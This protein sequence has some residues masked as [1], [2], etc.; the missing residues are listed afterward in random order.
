MGRTLAYKRRGNSAA[1]SVHELGPIED[2]IMFKD[3]AYL[4]RGL[5][6]FE[7]WMVYALALVVLALLPVK[8]RTADRGVSLA[9]ALLWASTALDAYRSNPGWAVLAGTEAALL[10][11]IGSAWGRLRFEAR[12][13]F[14]AAAGTILTFYSLLLFP[15]LA[16]F[17][18]PL[19][20]RSAFGAPLP[21]VLFTCGILFLTVEP[22]ANLLLVLPLTWAFLGGPDGYRGPVELDGLEI[23]LLAGA[24]FLTLPPELRA[25]SDSRPSPGTAYKLAFRRRTAFGYGLWA[26]TLATAFLFVTASRWRGLEQTTISLALLSALGLVLWLAYPAWQSLW[27]RYLAWGAAKAGGR[28]QIWLRENWRWGLMLLALLAVLASWNPASEGTS[29]QTPPSTTTAENGMIYSIPG[30]LRELLVGFLPPGKVVWSASAISL[31]WLLLEAYQGRRRLVIGDFE[32]KTGDSIVWASGLGSQLQNELARIADLYKVI[33]EARPTRKS[34]VVE[35]VPGVVDPGTI[36]KEAIS[37]TLGSA[38]FGTQ[39]AALFTRLVSGPQLKG[40]VHKVGSDYVITASLSGGGLAFSWKVDSGTFGE[41]E[42]Q[43]PA[44]KDVPRALLGQLAYRIAT[45]LVSI[46]S[47]RW[48]AVRCFTEGLRHYR[49]IQRQ[50]DQS[51]KLREAERCLIR[52]LN[53]DLRF[54]QCHYNLGVVYRQLGELGSAESAFR[55]VLRENPDH[56]EACYALAE[57]LVHCKKHEDAMRFCEAAIDID[58]DDARAWDLWAYS[59]RHRE[60]RLT[61]AEVALEPSHPGWTQIRERKEIA[62][63]LAWRALCREALRGPSPAIQSEMTT[64]LLCTRNLAVVLTRLG[65]YQESQRVF[66]Q[67]TWL[68]PHDPYVGLYEGRTHF[69][70]RSWRRAKSALGGAFDEGLAARDRGLLWSTL[71]QAHAASEPEAADL[72][73]LRSAHQRFLDLVADASPADLRQV[74]EFSLEAPPRE[75]HQ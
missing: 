15:L 43:N 51:Y 36:L 75:S 13:G 10:L 24:L 46:G 73:S 5:R 55:R 1:R 68:A 45:D 71:A 12:T 2:S 17:Q 9:L 60:Q 28:I 65:L 63:A 72:G 44:D 22:I 74:V 21:L 26:L 3:F 64:A 47:P 40:V 34:D 14:W 59:L 11:G 42:K 20:D 56:F 16:L 25:M 38:G 54:T 30:K 33:D 70:T 37:T 57:T 4:A 6:G 67:A 41:D 7:D 69:W 66:Q 39:I 58:P 61:G 8:T 29:Q 23:A 62:V 18:A 49:E 35:V 48:R 32:D 27:Y 19:F 50:S 31:L 53:D 52:A